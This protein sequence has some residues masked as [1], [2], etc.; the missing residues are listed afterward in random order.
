VDSGKW[1]GQSG[2][3]YILSREVKVLDVFLEIGGFFGNIFLR[4]EVKR[5][6]WPGPRLPRWRETANLPRIEVEEKM[7][8]E[9]IDRGGWERNKPRMAEKYGSGRAPLFSR[10]F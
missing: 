1:S 10:H 4:G 6:N 8:N 9:A 7:A 3:L 2:L 5:G